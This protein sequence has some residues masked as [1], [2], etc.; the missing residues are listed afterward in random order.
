[1]L[2]VLLLVVTPLLGLK[3]LLDV[4]VY[5][6]AITNFVTLVQYTLYDRCSLAYLEHVLKCINLTKG[7]FNEQRLKDKNRDSK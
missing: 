2:R 5:V 7:V 6:R 3:G 1:V 4:L